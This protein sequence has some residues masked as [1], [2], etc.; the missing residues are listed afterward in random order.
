MNL[1]FYLKVK[2]LENEFCETGLL[3]VP[4]LAEWYYD[5]DLLPLSLMFMP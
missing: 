3:C 2:S 5:N 4:K 1:K